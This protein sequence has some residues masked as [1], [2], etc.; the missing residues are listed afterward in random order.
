GGD[1]G[2]GALWEAPPR[3]GAV[4]R[5]DELVVERRDEERAALAHEALPDLDAILL[6]P[7]VEDDLG[8]VAAGRRDLG[9]GSVSRHDDRGLQA[10]ELRH[11]R[12]RLAVVARGVR[13]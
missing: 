11:E 13:D 1:W 5:H 2:G 4:P 7:V 10:E 9:G 12:D 8:A 3:R 6:V